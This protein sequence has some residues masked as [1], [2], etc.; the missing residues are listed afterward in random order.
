MNGYLREKF[1]PE[2]ITIRC[3]SHSYTA[4]FSLAVLDP[5]PA[6][7]H[8]FV[9]GKQ[10][11]VFAAVCRVLIAVASHG[12]CVRFSVVAARGLSNCGSQA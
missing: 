2:V 6:L 10:G 12:L 3:H 8:A 7:L 5:H 4:W 11:L 9:C 1:N